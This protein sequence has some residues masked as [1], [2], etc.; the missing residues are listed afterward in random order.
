MKKIL[1]GKTFELFL[2]IFGPNYKWNK[3][4]LIARYV[5]VKVAAV[6]NFAISM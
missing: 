3:D 4:K 2:S 6:K 1:Q 5:Y